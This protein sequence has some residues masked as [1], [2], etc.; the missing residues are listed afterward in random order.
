MPKLGIIAGGGDLP[1]ALAEHLRDAG[2]DYFIARIA[3]FAD[4]A[5]DEFPGETH[6]LGEVGAR[7]DA[8]KSAACDAV[9]FVGIVPRPDLS[10][11]K[12]DAM[13]MAVAP[14]VAMALREGDDALLRTLIEVH[15]EAGLNVVGADSVMTDLIAASGPLGAHAPNERDLADIKR[16]ARVVA[17]LG[18]L[19]IGQ[20]A[21]ACDG[22]VLAVEAQEG[23]DAMLARVAT[24]STTLRGTDAE[25]RGVLVKRPKPGQDRRIDLPAIGV[26]TIERAAQA[27]MSGIA[28]EAGGALIVRKRAVTEAADKAGLFV[29]G[30][31]LQDVS[32]Q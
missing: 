9:A 24:L 7:I 12:L 20:G 3:P 21:V 2:A 28:V 10:Q 18:D 1:I 17:A 4:P 26:A 13:G 25:R 8:I 30:F 19:D 6:N 31:T 23:T 32:E 15:A 5:L 27:G 29:C 16:A 22:V 14:K 11:L